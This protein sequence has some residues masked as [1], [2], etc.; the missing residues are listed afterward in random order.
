ML[1]EIRRVD[2]VCREEP[3][4]H[5]KTR[6]RQE[7]R[8]AREGKMTDQ[9][10]G[11]SWHSEEGHLLMVGWGGVG[12]PQRRW[13][14]RQVLEDSKI[15]Q[16]EQ[17]QGCQ[18]EGLGKPDTQRNCSVLE[19]PRQTKTFS[20]GLPPPP[21]KMPPPRRTV[22]KWA[23]WGGACLLDQVPLAALTAMMPKPSAHQDL[24]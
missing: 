3:H 2:R 11:C 13:E 10:K 14:P 9:A 24:E 20:P 19:A 4:S 8:M 5:G 12:G 6:Q 7:R 22:G 17:R 18:A 23:Q 1:W 21:H 15:W 16:R